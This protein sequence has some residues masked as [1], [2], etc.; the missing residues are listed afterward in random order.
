MI[1]EILQWVIHR[2]RR[3]PFQHPRWSGSIR[4]V[5]TP[6]EGP[7]LAEILS[8]A[9]LQQGVVT[10]RQCRGVGLF[11]DEVRRLCRERRWLRINK[12][13]Y[14]V[15]AEAT[16]GDMPR[17]ARIR[18][19]MLSAGP[20]AVAVLSTAAE[21]LGL[22]GSRATNEIHVSLPG[23]LARPFRYVDS[24]LRLHQLQLKP[25]QLTVV[26]GITVTAASRTVADLMLRSDRFT[27][28][29]LLD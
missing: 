23:D 27:A 20:A 1:V 25:D 7:P 8:V 12:G 14:F 17:L 2:L 5:L 19:A 6:Y 9:S 16:E 15:S 22:A 3:W 18:A 28:V 10:A 4:G 26:S 29:S 11:P 21:L 24:A 13:I